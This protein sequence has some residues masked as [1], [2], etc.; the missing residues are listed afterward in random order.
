M[1]LAWA[2]TGVIAMTGFTVLGQENKKA[3]E[4]R[5]DLIDAQVDLRE[6]KID[7]AADYQK[8]KKEAELKI[9]DNEKKIAAL[10]E[11]NW[12]ESRAAEQDY[13]K[14]IVALQEKNDGLKK[15]IKESDGTKTSKWSAFK[16]EFNQDMDDL[17]R[18]IKEIGS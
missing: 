6:A 3:A 12:N 11:K 1:I 9:N 4:A 15:K 13:E 10:K 14:R 17:G 5:A 8:F 18:A 16:R 7:S 2:I